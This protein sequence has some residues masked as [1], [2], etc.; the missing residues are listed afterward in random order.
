MF[1]TFY[2]PETMGAGG[3][4]TDYD[5]DSD[6]DSYLVQGGML[7]STRTPADAHF[8]PGPTQALTHRLYRN[9]LTA[10]TARE[11]TPQ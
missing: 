8:P 4:L 1:G 9:E 7:T 2:F 3:A 5:D 10:N 11:R 6:F